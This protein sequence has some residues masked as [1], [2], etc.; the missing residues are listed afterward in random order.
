MTSN[1]QQ[2]YSD[3]FS[4]SGERVDRFVI[5]LLKMLP[6]DDRDIPESV[7]NTFKD[8][9]NHYNPRDVLRLIF[10]NSCIYGLESGIRRED[11]R[12]DI[13]LADIGLRTLEIRDLNRRRN[14]VKDRI[15]KEVK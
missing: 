15:T 14:I 7:I 13:S 5:N 2:Q 8:L 6:K 11:P 12:F 9:L 1:S 3:L 10:Y 4:T